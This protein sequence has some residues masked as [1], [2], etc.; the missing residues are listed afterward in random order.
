MKILKIYFKNINSL[1]G[2]HL[3]DFSQAPLAN[4]GVFAITGPNG[5]GKTSILDAITLALYGET[6]R[7]DRPAEHVMTKQTSESF[8][9]VE[10][11][12]QEQRFRAR[13]AVQLQQNVLTPVSMSLTRLGESDELLADNAVQVRS[14]VAE[15]VGLDFRS[16]T[17]STLLAQGDFAAFLNALDSERLD[18]LEKIVSQDIYADYKQEIIN[19]AETAQQK[20]ADLH[21]DLQAIPLLDAATQ[22]AS[23]LDLADFK[24]QRAE[25]EFALQELTQQINGMQELSMLDEQYQQQ[26]KRQQALVQQQQQLATDLQRIAQFAHLAPLEQE[27]G[28]AETLSTQVQTDQQVLTTFQ[29]ELQQLQAQVETLG[30]TAQNSVLGSGRTLAD[31]QEIIS[32]LSFQAEMLQNENH[33]EI[34][35]VQSLEQQLADKRAIETGVKQWLVDHQGEATL[36]DGFP[37]IG[38]MKKLAQDIAELQNQRKAYA[39]WSKDTSAK[40]K[41]IQGN[42]QNLQ[43]TLP[44]LQQKISAYEA[45]MASLTRGL[46]LE[47]LAELRVEQRGKVRDFK[48]V[49]ELAKIYSR[50]S[51]GLLVRLGLVRKPVELDEASITQRLEKLQLQLQQEEN[52]KK[53]LEHAVFNE[54]LLKKMQADRLHLV[55][56][57]PCPL[58]GALKHPYVNEPPRPPDSQQ[59]LALQKTRVQNLSNNYARGQQ[60]LAAAQKQAQGKQKRK[61]QITRLYS[62]WSTLCNRLGIVS[63]ELQIG[64]L[65]LMKRLLKEQLTEFKDLEVIYKKSRRLEQGISKAKQQI[66][67]Q[68]AKLAQLQAA[69]EELNAG[70]STRPQELDSLEQN[71]AQLTA[72]EKPLMDKVLGQLTLLGEKMPAKGKEDALFDRLNQRRQDYQMYLL[73]EK[74]VAEEITQLQQKISEGHAIMMGQ[75]QR[76]Q[77]CLSKLRVEQ[78]GGVE[79]AVIEKQRLIS[80]QNSRIAQ[81]QAELRLLQQNLQS[82]AIEAGL[83]SFAQLSEVLHLLPQQVALSQQ[84]TTLTTELQQ[85]TVNLEQLQQQKQTQ[86][87]WAAT[88]KSIPEL[89]ADLHRAQEQA[90]IARLEIERLENLLLKQQQRLE[91]YQEVSSKITEQRALSELCQREL[92]I[93]QQET[94]HAFR[95]K[96]QRRMAD[97][98]LSQTNLILEKISGRFYVR[99]QE[100][101]QGLALEIEDTFQGNQRRLPKTLSGGE[102]FVVSLAL[103]LGLAELASNGHSIDSLFLDEGFG[104]LDAEA[105][106]TVVSTLEGLQTQGKKVGVISHVEG[107]RKRIKTQIEMIKKPNGLSELRALH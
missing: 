23:A 79:L 60:Q 3:I 43:K 41:A 64:N 85:L 91:K 77:E 40:R 103:A 96:V 88:V 35:L 90:D 107:V 32:A 100:T 44:D 15:I 34:A 74:S 56:G 11:S 57:E 45:E 72:E 5:S 89:N 69:A 102:G 84:Q 20:L 50:F 55:N 78:R 104:N 105:L 8:A 22:E 59:A 95:R 47:E 29:Q 51:D 24:A 80:E 2:E 42:I 93:A 101:E 6:F 25:L 14:L 17:R 61:D 76:L 65:R 73:R 70:F 39:K 4:A 53:T 94:G 46:S 92:E 54:A 49:L 38:R 86:Y 48:E 97:K 30:I 75:Q 99:Q 106:Y 66:D 87:A 1:Q 98:L 9:Q 10:F 83:A 31:Q 19:N 21:T 71:L 68:Q 27:H 67:K 26:Q 58:C 36:L 82:R 18:I 52:L 33:S 16:F 81:A 7:F 37:D 13:W 28:Y 12:V 62:D 63:P